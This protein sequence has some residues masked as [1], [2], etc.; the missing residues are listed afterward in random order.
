MNKGSIARAAKYERRNQYHLLWAHFFK[1]FLH[2]DL[3]SPQGETQITLI[4]ILSVLTVP[5]FLF[6]YVAFKKYFIYLKST[7]PMIRMAAT[8]SDQG[9]LIAFSMI[10]MGFL[11]ILEWDALLPE[12]RDFAVLTPLPIR[13]KT[14]LGAKVT[15][16]LLFLWFFT[17]AIN[18]FP[19]LVLPWATA[20][21]A[22]SLITLLWRIAVHLVSVGVAST[23][24]F[25]SCVTLHGL[26]VNFP[27]RH[28]L[29]RVSRAAQ[30]LL[31]L[32]LV[33]ALFLLPQ[34]SFAIKTLKQTDSLAAYLPPLWY[35]GLYQT[36]LGN[37]DPVYR[38]LAGTALTALGLSFA[39]SLLVY[40]FSFRERL[41]PWTEAREYQSPSVPRAQAWVET[42]LSRLTIRNE[43]EQAIFHFVIKTTLRSHKHRLY[44]GAYAAVGLA[45]SG[46]TTL[47][48]VR[49]VEEAT[50][51]QIQS[52]LLPV[53]LILLFFLL[54]GMRYIFTI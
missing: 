42:F 2:N 35:L 13:R 33:Q 38:S 39:G 9:L 45:F 28:S 11:A 48:S 4:H 47:A 25:F 40:I 49:W 12:R 52:A 34:L 15:A 30:F 31:L 17:T 16:L 26:L 53:P 50:L 41:S 7:P 32:L 37:E 27:G 36:L 21:Q 5:G 14:L 51:E 46:V 19:A 20:D 18:L 24:V 44:L 6:A 10:A 22:D 54:V 43:V 1:R 3:I 23:F 29:D 8:L